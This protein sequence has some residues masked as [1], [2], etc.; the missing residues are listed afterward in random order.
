ML[1]YNKRWAAGCAPATEIVVKCNI[2]AE[3]ILKNLY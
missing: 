3:N 2:E 1:Q